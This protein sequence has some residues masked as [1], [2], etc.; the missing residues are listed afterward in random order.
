MLRIGQELDCESIW[1]INR[2]DLGYDISFDVAKKQLLKVLNDDNQRIFVYEYDGEIV[3]YIHA[4][5]YDL[6]Y[7][8]PMKVI[9]GLA[10]K[11]EFRRNGIGGLLLLMVEDWASDTQTTGIKLN[12]GKYRPEAK[13]FLESW[14]Y[15]CAKEQLDYRKWLID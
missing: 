5:S 4:S 3:G 12:F 13:A 7:T 15:E 2:D 8:S 10:V 14:G 11:K 6:L 9:L 1:Q